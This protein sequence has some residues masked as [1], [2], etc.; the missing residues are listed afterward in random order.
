MSF[1]APLQ[2][3]VQPMTALYT[4]PVSGT[5][6]SVDTSQG[7]TALIFDFNPDDPLYA[8]DLGT[9]FSWPIGSM[10]IL[11]VWQPSF[12]VEP[13][14]TYNRPGDWMDG[15]NPLNKFIQGIIVTSGFASGKTLS[16]QSGDDMSVHTLWESPANF[17]P[18]QTVAFSCDPFISH[19]VRIVSTDGNAWTD[20]GGAQLVYQP[21]PELAIEWQTELVA[22]DL[23]GWG[24]LREMNLVYASSA[25]VTVNLA[26]DA[27][28]PQTYTFP[29]TTTG[30]VAPSTVPNK[31]KLKQTLQANKFKLTSFQAI[32]GQPFYLFRDDLEFKIKQWGS[33][34]PYTVIKPY[35][36]ASSAGAIV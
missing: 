24:H 34:S 32:S 8:R 19:N 21:W 7:R 3:T 1:Y 12:I 2:L 20:Y 22:L 4:Q 36:G 17:G 6:M 18:Q 9:I 33:S 14:S 35:G 10:T 25:P 29:A 15:G 26:F 28:P 13:E 16:L 27:Y 11:D 30:S 31:S 5:S 23:S